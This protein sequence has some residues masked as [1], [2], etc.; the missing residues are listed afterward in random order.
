MSYVLFLFD[1]ELE[2]PRV[3]CMAEDYSDAMIQLDTFAVAI[4][5]LKLGKDPQEVDITD[6][7]DAAGQQWQLVPDPRQEY[8]NPEGDSE[9]LNLL[10]AGQLHTIFRFSKLNQSIDQFMK[11]DTEAAVRLR[12]LHDEP[13][14]QIK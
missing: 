2:E 14:R 9:R 3:L 8:L 11:E 12:T 10:D 5:A 4:L 13:V 6:E 1:T 7:Y